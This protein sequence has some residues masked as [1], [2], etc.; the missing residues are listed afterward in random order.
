MMPGPPWLDF[1]AVQGLDAL[2]LS[3]VAGPE[4]IRQVRQLCAG[5]G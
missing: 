3:C 2:S 5:R 4:D 1:A